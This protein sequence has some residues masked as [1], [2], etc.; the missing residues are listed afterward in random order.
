MLASA[1]EL[2]D[3]SPVQIMKIHLN[4]IRKSIKSLLDIFAKVYRPRMDSM[5]QNEA[6][7]NIHENVAAG[8]VAPIAVD[9]PHQ[10]ELVIDKQ[11]QKLTRRLVEFCLKHNITLILNRPY[12]RPDYLEKTDFIYKWQPLA[13]FIRVLA[14]NDQSD[15]SRNYQT[16]LRYINPVKTSVF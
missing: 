16:R 12:F 13:K 5:W 6:F 15:S 14:E 7:Q 1:E 9:I 2:A 11:A 10:D 4:A 3:F 8:R